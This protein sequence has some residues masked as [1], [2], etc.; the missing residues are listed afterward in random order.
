MTDYDLNITAQLG[1]GYYDSP[2]F[3]VAFQSDGDIVY[4]WV[5]YLILR[6]INL[7]Y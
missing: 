6:D 3:V 7:V 1:S 2:V 4:D 5:T